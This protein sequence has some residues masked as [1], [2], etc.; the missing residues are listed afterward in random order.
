MFD[1][2]N[3]WTRSWD[4]R[5]D[6]LSMT[7]M[8]L[9]KGVRLEGLKYYGKTFQSEIQGLINSIHDDPPAAITPEV[10]E[11]FSRH[12]YEFDYSAINENSKGINI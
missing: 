1:P 8:L 2:G 12:G 11:T 3:G 5:V 6:M 7:A 4:K 10:K 9:D